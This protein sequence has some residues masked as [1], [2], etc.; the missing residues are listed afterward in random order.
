MNTKSSVHSTKRSLIKFVSPVEMVVNGQFLNPTRNPNGFNIIYNDV[1]TPPILTSL[2]GWTMTGR[3]VYLGRGVTPF[4]NFTVPSPSREQYLIATIEN[5]PTPISITQSFNISTIGTY[6][7]TF[8]MVAR[9]AFQIPRTVCDIN[10]TSFNA[11]NSITVVDYEWRSTSFSTY[12]AT[13]GA[14]PLQISIIGSN[15]QQI[16]IASMSMRLV[17]HK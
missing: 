15:G 13:A 9:L 12:I 2:P 8:Y 16:S 11:T 7:V 17:I 1:S 5:P 3:S 14:Y 4:A 10:G 6:E